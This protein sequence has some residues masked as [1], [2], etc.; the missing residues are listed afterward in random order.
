MEYA[1]RENNRKGALPSLQ[2]FQKRRPKMKYSRGSFEAFTKT[3]GTITKLQ[4]YQS[5]LHQLRAEPWNWELSLRVKQVKLN[6]Q[7]LG[8]RV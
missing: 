1:T 7:E 6:L 3:Q 2:A 4:G 8:V 5:L